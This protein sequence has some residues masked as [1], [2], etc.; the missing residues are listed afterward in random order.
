LAVEDNTVRL[1][2]PPRE[3]L[4]PL[5]ED[6]LRRLSRHGE[7]SPAL[8]E[9][10]VGAVLEACE[11]LL[12][13]GRA[14][15]LEQPFELVL[16][17]SAEAA[18]VA[19]AY[20]GKIPLNPHLSEPYEVPTVSSDP[21][22]VNLDT[23]W[24]HLIKHRMDRVFFE[25]KGPVHLLRLIKYRRE[26]GEEKRLWFLGMAPALRPGLNVQYTGPQDK[27]DAVLLQDFQSGKVFRF[28]PTEALAVRLMDG[29]RTLYDIYLQHVE[30]VGP[31]S[32][33][34]LGVLYEA[35][36]SAGMLA[37]PADQA[38]QAKTRP[39][40]QRLTNPTYSIPHADAVVETVHGWVKPLVSPLGTMLLLAVGFSGAIP[41]WQG[42]ARL[43]Q[44]GLP[45]LEDLL[46]LHPLSLLAIYALQM[47]MVAC[48]ELAHGVTCKHFGGRVPRMGMMLYLATFIFFCD[49]T[50]AWNFPS[51]T[52]RL[53]VSLAGPLVTFALLG[54]CLWA[55]GHFLGTRSFWEPVF[56]LSSLL[57][58]FGLVMNFNPFIRM[59]AYYMLMD[60]TG[61]SNLR[62]KSFRFL[63]RK[64]LRRRLRAGEE[65]QRYDERQRAIF[66]L[67]GVLGILVTATMFVL[68][69][70]HLVRQATAQGPYSGSVIVGVAALALALLSLSHKA[71][72]RL[73]LLRH[74]EYKIK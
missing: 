30:E 22:D 32:P 48:H 67:Y 55:T 23:L 54:A 18:E 24:L 42:Y 16:D 5:A 29:R 4:L 27:P 49:T 69:F 50:S 9:M 61:I 45:S 19:I 72:A 59:D 34:R 47:A 26:E 31:I 28:G 63:G 46:L 40:L 73:R 51:K 57:F 43:G 15:S 38:G 39:W 37:S 33:H 2:L 66:W 52:Q 56:L 1:K 53:L 20:D 7:L 64:L 60:L 13:A 6:A 12:R 58:F 25:V 68:P 62:E 21:E 74:R 14:V 71:M 8:E 36:E 3:S 35:L 11:E 10:L 17:F 70:V 65:E 44:E 41:L